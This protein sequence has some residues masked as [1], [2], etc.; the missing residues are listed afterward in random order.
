[1][2]RLIVT[3][4][5]PHRYSFAFPAIITVTNGGAARA[6]ASS[7]CALSAAPKDLPSCPAAFFVSYRLVFAVKEEKG[8]GGEAINVTPAGCH[9]VTGLG[10]VR[11]TRLST[12]F[13]WILGSAMRLENPG[14]PTFEGTL[15]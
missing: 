6:V 7:A 15:N 3:R 11:T 5:A 14:L 10:D 4:S 1:V 12:G 8:M 13:Y 9:I 2:D